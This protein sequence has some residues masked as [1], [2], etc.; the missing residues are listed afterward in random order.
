VY[1]T[2]TTAARCCAALAAEYE[3]YMEEERALGW[4]SEATA[5]PRNAITATVGRDAFLKQLKDEVVRFNA[6]AQRLF[7]APDKGFMRTREDHA[8]RQ[9]W[10]DDDAHTAGNE[11]GRFESASVKERADKRKRKQYTEWRR[12]SRKPR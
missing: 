10:D 12:H 6:I 4:D 11:G 8:N 5:A 2:A 1:F 9:R 3:R 7:W